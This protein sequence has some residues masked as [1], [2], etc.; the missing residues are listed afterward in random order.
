M[1]SKQ[2]GEYVHPETGYGENVFRV[3]VSVER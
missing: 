3:D 2:L 1:V